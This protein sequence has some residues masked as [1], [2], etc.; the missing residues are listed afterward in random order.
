MTARARPAVRIGDP[1]RLA[2]VRETA[3]RCCGP[4]AAA[5]HAPHV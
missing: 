1:R 3:R 5:L 2:S 4:A